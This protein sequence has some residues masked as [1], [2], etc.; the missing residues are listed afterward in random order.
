MANFGSGGNYSQ[1]IN[2]S[3]QP[4]AL[5]LPEVVIKP[6]K[7]WFKKNKLLAYASAALLFGYIVITNTGKPEIKPRGNRKLK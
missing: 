2:F 4:V 1:V 6:V 7:N 5:N 3:L